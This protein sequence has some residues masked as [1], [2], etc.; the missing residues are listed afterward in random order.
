MDGKMQSLHD[1]CWLGDPV[2]YEDLS[3]KEQESYNAASLMSQMA[4]WGYLEGQKI[5]G[6]KW[7]ADILFYRSSDSSVLKVQLKGR[8]TLSKHYSGKD[9]HIAFKSKKCGSWF[10]YS[11]DQVLKEVL[12]RGHLSGTQSWD[13]TGGWS[14]HNEPAWLREILNSWCITKRG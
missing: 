9:I 11:H 1:N 6:D 7:G 14:W 5:N 12:A 3:G 10:L 2:V 4:E 13:V 8:V